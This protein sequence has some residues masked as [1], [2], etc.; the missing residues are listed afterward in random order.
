MDLVQINTHT[1]FAL[2]PHPEQ[3][4]ANEYLLHPTL[5]YLTIL[6]SPSLQK[7]VLVAKTT[8]KLT[9]SSRAAK[10]ALEHINLALREAAFAQSMNKLD[11]LSASP[12]PI[13]FNSQANHYS[14]AILHLHHCL[15]SFN[16][17]SSC[18]L[19]VSPPRSK[20]SC[21]HCGDSSF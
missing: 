6:H 12:D 2:G 3:G 20:D 4:C 18:Q 9:P 19:F 17:L 7:H 16:P 15:V 10:V 5:R 1:I 13:V 8:K 21:L 11:D 14:I